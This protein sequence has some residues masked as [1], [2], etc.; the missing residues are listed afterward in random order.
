MGM[1]SRLVGGDVGCAPSDEARLK[2]SDIVA[3]A[4]RLLT[5]TLPHLSIPGIV[6]PGGAACMG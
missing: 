1:G 3:T 2:V 5:I 4:A 6:P